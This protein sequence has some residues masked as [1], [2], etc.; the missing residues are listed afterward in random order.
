[1]SLLKAILQSQAT[2][3]LKPLNQMCPRFLD[4]FAAVMHTPCQY[5]Q[6]RAGCNTATNKDD[7]LA[8]TYLMTSTKWKA[9]FLLCCWALK[10]GTC[11]AKWR[12]EVIANSASPLLQ[13]PCTENGASAAPRN[14][15][16]AFALLAPC[17]PLETLPFRFPACRKTKPWI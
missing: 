7:T 10:R 2:H 1:M 13:F 3:P 17:L 9:H 6:F 11:L 12:M 4:T 14:M 16:N 8:H 5:A 15:G